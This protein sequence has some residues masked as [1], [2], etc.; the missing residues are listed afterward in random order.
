MY[1]QILINYGNI[2]M[3]SLSKLVLKLLITRKNKKHNY[4][5]ISNTAENRSANNSVSK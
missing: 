1:K 5:E 4:V 2:F 3:K